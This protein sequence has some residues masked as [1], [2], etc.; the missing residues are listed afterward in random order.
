MSPD[1]GLVLCLS[2][3]DLEP[4]LPGSASDDAESSVIVSRIQVF[5]LCLND[6]HDLFA[7]YLA[8][9]CLVRFL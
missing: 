4:H 6:I 7:R 2:V 1:R 3:D 5:R 9:L 8:D